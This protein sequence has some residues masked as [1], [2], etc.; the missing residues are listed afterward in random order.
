MKKTFIL[1]VSSLLWNT[2][3]SAQDVIVKKDGS[4]II[5]KVLEINQSNVKYKKYSNQRG[6]IYTINKSDLLSINYENGEKETYE[7]T[8]VSTF[9]SNDNKQVFG[10][11]A[12]PDAKN[13]SIINKYN[14][15]SARFAIDETPKKSKALYWAGIL[16]VDT[17][18]IMSSKYLEASLIQ[19]KSCLMNGTWTHPWPFN[20]HYIIELKNKSNQTIYIDLGNT[21]RV[22]KNGKYKVY[23]D[24]KQTTIGH[25]SGNGVSLNLGSVSNV[26]GISGPVGTI[27]NGVTIGSEKG[28]SASTTYSKQRVVAIPPQATMIIE[29]CDWEHVKGTALWKEE[30]CVYKSY[31]EGFNYSRL[32]HIIHKNETQSFNFDNSPCKY[33]YTITYSLNETF[34]KW[35]ALRI[36]VYA[37][38]LCGEL[39]IYHRDFGK[40]KEKVIN[41]TPYTIIIGGE[42]T[43]W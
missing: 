37:R 27:A 28:H 33:M 15:Y 4:T 22:D 8:S 7:N 24:T 25:N 38:L 26:L 5:S 6:P 40:I 21:F 14:N 19:S 10:D 3:V 9:L 13:Q 43:L 30:N 23:Y 34:D 18:S 20:G 41:Y 1:F 32:E 11:I 17:S 39:K 2:T 16:A 35:E 42:R 36:N 12:K 31:C 29:E